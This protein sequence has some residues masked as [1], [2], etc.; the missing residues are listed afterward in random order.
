MFFDH[1]G[2]ATLVDVACLVTWRSGAQSLV[3]VARLLLWWWTAGLASVAAETVTCLFCRV[4]AG[5][6]Q[7]EHL[8][9]VAREIHEFAV[10]TILE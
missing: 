8:S 9:E 3:I 5:E 7:E 6:A 1:H 2:S 10:L 4:C